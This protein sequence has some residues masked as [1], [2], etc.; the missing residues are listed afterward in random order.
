MRRV[1]GVVHGPAA[2]LT[3]PQKGRRPAARRPSIGLLRPGSSSPIHP[4]AWKGNSEKFAGQNSYSVLATDTA[5]MSGIAFA[6]F[7]LLIHL[8]CKV[9]PTLSHPAPSDEQGCEYRP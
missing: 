3:A 8:D 6:R 9:A 1:R 5:S 2:G 7:P 4:S